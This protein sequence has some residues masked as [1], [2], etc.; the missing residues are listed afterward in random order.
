MDTAKKLTKEAK[1]LQISVLK[2][3]LT[4]AISG[5][6]VVAALAWNSFIQEFVNLY[7]KKYFPQGSGV[8]TLFIYAVIVT[9]LAVV[10]T[11]NLSRLTSKL[12]GEVEKE[13]KKK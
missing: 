1:D 6:G 12:E 10:V 5:F 9:I 8:L 11:M 4:L 2:Q 13:Q 7:I 3:M